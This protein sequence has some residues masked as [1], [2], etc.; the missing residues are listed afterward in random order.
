M[1]L[2]RSICSLHAVGAANRGPAG[3]AV[4][5]ACALTLLLGACSSTPVAQPTA[6]AP[7]AKDA[8]APPALQ[9]VPA[10]SAAAVPTAAPQDADPNN[11][12]GRARSVY[13]GFDEYAVPAQASS[14]IEQ[15]GGQLMGRPKLHIRVEGN[16][17]ERGGAEYNLALGT[18]RAE[19]VRQALL[20]RGVPPERVEAVSFGKERPKAQGSDESAWAENRRVD[21]VYPR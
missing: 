2:P 17:D 13:F 7:T 15:H 5:A 18:K 14:V 21:L 8:A 4:A 11:L 1:N 6:A 20:A 16:T 19:A 3:A 9:P 12:A 10:S